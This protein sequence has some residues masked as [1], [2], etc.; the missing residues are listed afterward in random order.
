[1]AK[2]KL[3]AIGV[4]KL[5]EPGRYGDGGGLWLQVRTSGKSWLFRYTRKGV[6]RHLG[7]GSARDVS[8]AEARTKAAECRK[9]LLLGIDPLEARRAAQAQA[10]FEI[11]NATSFRECAER[12]IVSQETAWRNAK[13]RQQW[14]NTLATYAYPLLGQAAVS[15]VDTGLIMKVL[16]PIWTEKP[17]TAS[18][19]RGRI[20]SVL[21]WAKARDYRQGDNPA[22]WRGH[23]DKLLPSR[24][25]VANVRHHA[26]LPYPEIPAFMEQLRARVGVSARALE[27]LILTSTRTS[28]AIKARWI[29]FDFGTKSWVIP[30]ERMKAGHDYRVPLSDRAMALLQELPSE[31]EFVFPGG[32]A[33]TG[34][35][36]NMAL[37]SLLR[38]MG[39]TDLTS[40][41]FRSSFRDWAAERTTY[42]NHIVEMALAHTIGNK[43]EAAY[44]RGDLLAKRSHLMQDW[45]QYCFSCS[46]LEERAIPLRRS[47]NV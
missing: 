4:E 11:A 8:L 37:L 29:E 42:P 36:S 12:Y 40:H 30:A 5:R 27:L 6:A 44:R 7:L 1:M 35:L 38:R 39:R 43:V 47:G 34:H 16:D 21:D 15:A 13:H 28:E 22:R 33:M 9:R 14:R 2:A 18:R 41:G 24:R 10:Q 23:L 26:A 46:E 25:R 31:T 17:E 3:T 32:R 19:V 20:E 45:A